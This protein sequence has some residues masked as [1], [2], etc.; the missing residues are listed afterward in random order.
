MACRQVHPL[1]G[2]V[3]EV[4]K[5]IRFEGGVLEKFSIA[6]DEGFQ[7]FSAIRTAFPQAETS[8]QPWSSVKMMGKFGRGAAPEAGMVARFFYEGGACRI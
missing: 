5:G 6:A 3:L 2:I 4:V 8:P 7:G 1:L